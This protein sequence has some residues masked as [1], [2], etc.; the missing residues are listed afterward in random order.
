M[1]YKDVHPGNY[2]TYYFQQLNLV[3]EFKMVFKIMLEE[4][5]ELCPNCDD[6]EYGLIRLFKSFHSHKYWSYA[7]ATRKTLTY[8][9]MDRFL[10]DYSETALQLY[11]LAMVNKE[12]P[13]YSTSSNKTSDTK[14]EDFYHRRKRE[15]SANYVNAIHSESSH[16]LAEGSS[17]RGITREDSYSDSGDETWHLAGAEGCTTKQGYEEDEEDD[18][19]QASNETEEEEDQD[20]M[21]VTNMV[22]AFADHKQSGK[23]DKKDYPC[24]RKIMSGNC[25]R[26]DC[27]YGHRRDVLLKGAGDMIVKLRAF[28]QSQAATNQQPSSG[29]ATP[30]RVLQKDK[31]KKN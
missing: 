14:K 30:Y 6:K 27:P 5:K 10:D 23:A 8:S 22:A 29:A 25:D 9:R 4:N 28:E 17:S 26:N 16:K 3:E 12:M 13:W 20:E 24:L 31:Y 1:D 15:I 2:E 18:L 19:S 7:Y 11:S 21:L